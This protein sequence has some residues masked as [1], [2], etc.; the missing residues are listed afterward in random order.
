MRRLLV[1]LSGLGIL[2]I[3]LAWWGPLEQVVQAEPCCSY[4]LDCYYPNRLC[5]SPSQAYGPGTADCSEE[6]RD[7]CVDA[8]Q[9]GCY[10]EWSGCFKNSDCCTNVY[11]GSDWLCHVG[12]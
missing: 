3:A 6:Y 11:C 7:Y 5:K 4:G 12:C 9:Q 2:S 8:P 10:E 1:N